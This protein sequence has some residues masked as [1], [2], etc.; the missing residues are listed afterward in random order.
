MKNYLISV[1]LIF[2]N[3]NCTSENKTIPVIFLT[4]T[5]TIKL[6][7]VDYFLIEG[8][9]DEKK[10]KQII[11][12]YIK[13]TAVKDSMTK[14]NQYDM[15]FYKKSSSLN[16]SILEKYPMESRYKLT[17]VERPI[18]DYVWQNGFFLVAIDG[19]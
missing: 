5:D 17:I 7:R 12:D 14:Y 9:G 4:E 6:N 8:S 2:S 3:Y 19:K 1:F 13:K 11:D 15:L 10:D 18:I 16:L